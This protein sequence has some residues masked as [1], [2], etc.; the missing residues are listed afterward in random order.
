[1]TILDTNVI[2]ELMRPSPVRH[3]HDWVEAQAVTS[4]YATAIAQAEV[5]HGIQLM[6]AGRRRNAIELAAETIFDDYFA[7]RVLAFGSD[8][9][10]AYAQI[11]AS[12]RSAGRPISQLDAQIAAIAASTGAA[13]ATRNISDFEE[14]GITV[15]DPWLSR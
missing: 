7:G 12:R 2:S 6:P 3:V 5:L 9:A 8:A 14:C 10:R 1:M 15:I 13:L 4:L 11:A